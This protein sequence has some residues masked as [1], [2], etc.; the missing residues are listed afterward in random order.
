MKVAELTALLRADLERLILPDD[1]GRRR[2][3]WVKCINPRF[4]PVVIVRLARFFYLIRWLRPLSLLLTWLNVF[5]F[6]IEVT[7]RCEIGPGLMLPHT[8]G[9]VIGAA[10]IGSNVTIFQGATLGA[11]FADLAFDIQQRPVVGHHVVI[12]AG[13]KVL[14][15]IQLGDHAVV[16]ANS[17]LTET[18]PPG[19][20]AIGVP[21]QIKLP[22]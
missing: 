4:M 15:G 13:A 10:K 9:T 5:I 21:A 8:V 1:S 6:G 19:A 16:A 14:G 3:S 18:L 17:L 2:V 12:G 11:K 22:S 20:L 7:A